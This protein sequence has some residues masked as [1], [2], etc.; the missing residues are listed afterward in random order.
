MLDGNLC[1]NR[2]LQTAR[3]RDIVS[4]WLLPSGVKSGK[5]R[6]AKQNR[7]PL[8]SPRAALT[9]EEIINL[10]STSSKAEMPGQITLLLGLSAAFAILHRLLLVPFP[11]IVPNLDF[12]HVLCYALIL[13]YTLAIIWNGWVYP[14]VLDPLRHLPQPKVRVASFYTFFPQPLNASTGRVSIYQILL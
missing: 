9:Q 12:L 3:C 2:S 6:T 11:Q 5:I 4:K 14:I 1:E 8:W 13:N 10:N 7:K